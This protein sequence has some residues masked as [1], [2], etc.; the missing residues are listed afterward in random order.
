MRIHHVIA[1][2]VLFSNSF[3]LQAQIEKTKHFVFNLDSISTIKINVSDEFVVDFW[4]GNTMLIETNIQL[5]DANPNIF[6]SNDK[7]GRYD[8]LSSVN[9]QELTIYPKFTSRKTLQSKTQQLYEIVKLKL[10]ISE[11]FQM[12]DPNTY[13]RTTVPPAFRE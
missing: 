10:Y 3:N 6:K 2:F 9:A 12:T 7:E 1:F 11:E 8:F 4:P 13:T 5:F